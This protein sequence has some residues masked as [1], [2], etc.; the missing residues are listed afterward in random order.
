MGIEGELAMDFPNGG[1]SF[2]G[3]K[4]SK[5]SPVVRVPF[6]IGNAA[7]ADEMVLSTAQGDVPVKLIR[8]SAL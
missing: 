3:E 7:R 5:G 2:T 6:K 1:T 8:V 4:V